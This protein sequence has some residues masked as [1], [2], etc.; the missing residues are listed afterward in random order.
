MSTVYHFLDTSWKR[1]VDRVTADHYLSLTADRCCIDWAKRKI[2]PEEFNRLAL[3]KVSRHLSFS[4]FVD[5]H[6]LHPKVFQLDVEEINFL[7][8]FS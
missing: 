2:S 6:N 5:E 3:L 8:L 1:K 7:E 4:F